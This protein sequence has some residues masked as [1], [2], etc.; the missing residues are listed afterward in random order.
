MQKLTIIIFILICN[1]TFGQDKNDPTESLIAEFKSEMKKENI[2]DFFM[3]KHITY[4]SARIIDLKDPNSCNKN[5]YYFWIYGFWKNGNDTYIKKYDN[6]GGFNSIKLT[7]SKPIK[8]YEEN[9]ETLKKDEVEFYIVKPDSIVNGKKYSFFSSRS[10]TPQ[11]YFWFYQDSTEFKND[12]DKYNL[13]TE[14]DNKNLNYESNNNL[15][16]V[17]LNL[18]CE[19]IIYGL[20]K[21][22]KFNRLK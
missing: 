2:S 12:F 21:K 17:K 9:I 10:H 8:F 14:E 7:D 5:G 4:G 1:L 11:R 16:I 18:I 22:K 13:E 19:E 15:S 6:C 3:V 20:E